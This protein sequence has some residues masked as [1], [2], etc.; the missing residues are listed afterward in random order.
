MLAA[1]GLGIPTATLETG[2][3]GPPRTRPLP[4]MRWWAPDSATRLHDSEARV[5]RTVNAVRAEIGGPPCEGVADLLGADEQFL[6]SFPELDHYPQ[7]PPGA[8]YVGSVFSL[9]TGIE[10]P[11]PA[12][13]GPRVF[14]Y[15]NAGFSHLEPLL[16]ALTGLR[17]A[18]L[19][20]SPGIAPAIAARHRGPHL[21]IV[22][23]PVN[24]RSVRADCDAAVCHGPGTAAA[25]LLG[26]RPLLLL[27]TQLEQYMA[28]RRIE[29]LGAGIVISPEV[30]PTDYA[31]TLRRLLT[32]PDLRRA[33]ERFAERH[34]GLE[35]STQFRSMAERCEALLS[36]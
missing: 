3:S 11:W 18:A 35:Q 13:G 4:P 20:H 6:C 28:A 1:G 31:A 9:D 19:V 32:D 15:V 29:D 7:R 21:A 16:Q 10:P 12:A 24:M 23:E 33:A 14:A 36:A 27:P 8:R 34:A 5:L 25:V 30:A 22:A 26:G 17:G 2:F